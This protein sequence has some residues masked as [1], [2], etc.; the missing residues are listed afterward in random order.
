[1]TGLPF[2]P[3]ALIFDL[4]GTLLDT[5]P[6]YTEA[7]QSVLDQYGKTFT[8][9]L[10]RKIMGGNSLA[11]ARTT[12]SELDVP[13]TPEEFLEQRGVHLKRL[14]PDTLEIT[15]ASEFL[16]SVSTDG[17]PMGLA[18]S[19][20]RS[21][22][23]IKIGDRDWLSLFE[24]VVCGDDPS[25]ENSK[26]APDIFLLCAERMGIDPANAIAFEDSRN[27]VQAAKSAGMKVIAIDSPYVGPG[28]LDGAD[29]VVDNFLA[30]LER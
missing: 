18:T 14:F 9:E 29:L 12:V 8:P 22:A 28:D 10:K 13:L 16:A 21:L 6:L 2:D 3:Q 15:G 23:E 7:A 27:G 4:D 24:T 19:S 26:P 25:L 17:P 20:L 30:F 11:G 1:M 5:E